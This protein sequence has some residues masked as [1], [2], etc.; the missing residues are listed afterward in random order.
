MCGY[1]YQ[2]FLALS[3]GRAWKQQNPPVAM[4]TPCVQIL[5]SKHHSSVKGTGFLGAK[6]IPGLEHG[7]YKMNP[8]HVFT[9]EN[10]EVLSA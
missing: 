2:Y 3:T 10:K 6:L 5:V 8:A 9:P 7:K 4:S 1:A